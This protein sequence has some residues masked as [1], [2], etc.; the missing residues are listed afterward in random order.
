MRTGKTEGVKS[1]VEEVLASLPEELMTEDVTDEVFFAIEESRLEDYGRLCEQLGGEGAV[2]PW[3]GRWVKELLG[4]ESI[5][6]VPSRRKN[7]L[8]E[9]YTKLR[10][11]RDVIPEPEQDTETGDEV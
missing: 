4:A 9:C 10:F 2:N 6:T 1:L 11:G 5:R 7:S 8:S 3:I